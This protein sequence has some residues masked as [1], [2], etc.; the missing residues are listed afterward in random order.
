MTAY[1]DHDAALV[2]HGIRLGGKGDAL[3]NALHAAG[4]PLTVDDLE[5]IA[6]PDL[7]RRATQQGDGFEHVG[8]CQIAP[9][10][11]GYALAAQWF[12]WLPGR[13]ATRDV[14][15][16]AYGY[17]LGGEGFGYLNDL[18][19]RWGD[20]AVTAEDIQGLPVQ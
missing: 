18:V 8:M 12:G 1:A 9:T 10:D 6:R 19:K 16:A 2:A 5:R 15:L 17:V 3:A 4:Q 20:R 11:N 13:Y 7:S 14:A